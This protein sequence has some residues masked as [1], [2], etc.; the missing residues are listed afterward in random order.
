MMQTKTYDHAPAAPQPLDRALTAAR[1]VLVVDAPSVLRLLH[2]QP[3]RQSVVVTQKRMLTA[4]MIATVRP[5]AVIGPLITANWDIV[6]LGLALEMLGYTGD[7]Y[8][9]T[10]PL[11]RAELVIREVS[12]L[13][14]G[15]KVRLLETA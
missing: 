6:D 10:R 1:T 4:E 14:Q 2:R 8:A 11:P 12:A 7:L 3:G 15:L 13:C 9:L 5:D